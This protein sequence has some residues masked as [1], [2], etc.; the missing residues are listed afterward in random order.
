MFLKSP[1]CT[2]G[3]CNKP[4][5]HW[6][7]QVP[8]FDPS[9]WTTTGLKWII[10]ST[11]FTFHQMRLSC[12]QTFLSLFFICWGI[13]T[14]QYFPFSMDLIHYQYYQ[15]LGIGDNTNHSLKADGSVLFQ[16]W[17]TVQHKGGI[18]NLERHHIEG[19]LP[20]NT[21]IPRL[22]G[23]GDP[24]VSWYGNVG[25]LEFATM[26][27][28]WNWERLSKNFDRRGWTSMPHLDRRL[29]CKQRQ[30]SFTSGKFEA[31]SFSKKSEMLS[32]PN[33]AFAICASNTSE[34]WL[35]QEN[36]SAINL[37]WI[38]RFLASVSD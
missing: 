30:L 28:T 22:F 14:A 37:S 33:H 4:L 5:V 29:Q 6:A 21:S 25:P 31:V 18:R 32:S 15:Y 34:S 24:R 35:S 13:D 9:H 38:P 26:V 7:L 16:Q 20:Q 19:C 1:P 8:S 23:G 12:T 36:G 10:T 27:L 2:Q 11:K 17:F 3:V